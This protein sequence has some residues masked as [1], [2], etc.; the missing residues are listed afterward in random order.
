MLPQAGGGPG[1]LPRSALT[2]CRP[3][4]LSRTP[5]HWAA[6]AGKAECVRSLLAL[7]VDS[8]LRDANESAALA[9]ALHCGHAACVRLLHR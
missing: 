4:P 5:L 8:S 1:T 9:Y 3:L 6:A 2:L 7:G